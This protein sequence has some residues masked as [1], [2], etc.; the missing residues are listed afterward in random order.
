[1]VEDHQKF[2]KGKIGGGKVKKKK[3]IIYI[4]V[5]TLLISPI[6][7][8]VTANSGIN[9]TYLFCELE[10][11]WKHNESGDIFVARVDVTNIGE[12]NA[13]GVIIKLENIPEDWT[14]TPEKY[15]L[16]ILSPGDTTIKYFIIERGDESSSIYAT[17]EAANAD[18]V[19]SDPIAI[20]IFPE[21]LLL[22]GLVCGV[23]VHRDI[24]KRKKR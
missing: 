12:Y 2:P 17:A 9:Q 19:I 5:V 4:L 16:C 21:V 20:P 24:K 7:G 13:C 6:I 15:T 1:M 3:N 10:T 23:I 8:T 22:L 18:K 14:V 11:H